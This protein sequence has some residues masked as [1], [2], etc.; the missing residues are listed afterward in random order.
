M[1]A[2]KAATIMTAVLALSFAQ[3]WASGGIE[4]Q[5][6]SAQVLI[7]EAAANPIYGDAPVRSWLPVNLRGPGIS[8]SFAVEPPQTPPP[9]REE[10]YYEGSYQKIC[11][12]DDVS[13]HD[14]FGG[15]ITHDVNDI[16][17]ESGDNADGSRNAN[18]NA[19]V[20]WPTE[21]V[22]R[23][24]GYTLVLSG[25]TLMAEGPSTSLIMDKD[26]A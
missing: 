16:M 26:C 7:K 4:A 8:V 24:H 20:W 12:W 10:P 14:D 3:A 19:Y 15:V 18:E 13:G 1:S 5:K 11:S 6:A 17:I 9:C 21:D 2:K 22:L 23:R 25:K